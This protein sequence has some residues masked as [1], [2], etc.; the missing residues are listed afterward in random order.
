ME[1]NIHGHSWKRARRAGNGQLQGLSD[2]F[3][4]IGPAVAMSCFDNSI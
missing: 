3:V 2:C 4:V 1:Q